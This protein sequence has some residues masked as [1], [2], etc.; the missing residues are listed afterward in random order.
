M[1][2]NLATLRP[3]VMTYVQ[4]LSGLPALI[5][6]ENEELDPDPGVPHLVVEIKKFPYEGPSFGH[7]TNAGRITCTYY[8]VAAQGPDAFDAVMAV[9]EAAFAPGFTLD[10]GSQAI[11][12]SRNPGPAPG[13]ILK[14]NA[15]FSYQQFTAP[16]YA[17]VTT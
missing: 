15:S 16:W 10:V 11:S 13:D 7:G 4:G 9:L 3:V 8:G 6:Q 17:L 1:Q 5:V 2:L 14:Y 12:I